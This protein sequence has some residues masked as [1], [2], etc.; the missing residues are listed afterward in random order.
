MAKGPPAPRNQRG[1]PPTATRDFRPPNRRLNDPQVR[2]RENFR[3]DFYVMP[4]VTLDGAMTGLVVR[5]TERAID[6]MIDRIRGGTPTGRWS[7]NNLQAEWRSIGVD[8]GEMEDRVMST[9][10][11]AAEPI[12][13]ATPTPPS[14][15]SRASNPAPSFNFMVQVLNLDA[16]WSAA[17]ERMRT[18]I[19]TD[20]DP[21]VP[22]RPMA[23]SRTIQPGCGHVQIEHNIVDRTMRV[24]VELS[25]PNDLQADHPEVSSLLGSA[26]TVLDIPTK[27][28]VLAVV[29]DLCAGKQ[30]EPH[31]RKMLD[32]LKVPHPLAAR[33]R[34]LD[35]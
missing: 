16:A 7:D 13:S 1:L 11:V 14:P 9:M 27:L 6:R 30:I 25:I 21:P 24:G 28:R 33:E 4:S 18:G 8:Y 32:D 15:V 2:E 31:S 23:M 19:F 35:L 17:Q 34:E 12:S 26:F 20:F 22:E 3:P 5:H 10:L 29:M